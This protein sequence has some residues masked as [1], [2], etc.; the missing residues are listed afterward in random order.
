MRERD[1]GRPGRTG[2]RLGVLVALL[3]LL[4]AGCGQAG[5]TAPG[6]TAPAPGPTASVPSRPDPAVGA[7]PDLAPYYGQVL[8][9]GDCAPFAAAP[10]QRLAFADSALECAR[11]RVPLDYTNPRGGRDAS[12][13]LLRRRA[14]SP[15]ARIGSLVINPGG[16]GA[17]GIVTAAGLSSRVE[18][19]ELGR[20]FDLVGFDPR[21]VGA[22]TPTVRC[23]TGPE[24]D[25]QRA[26]DDTDPSPA[27]VAATEAEAATVA[28]DCAART[29]VDVLATVGT[30]DVARDLDVLR[31][32]L[33]DAGL[34]YLGYSYG[35]RIGSTYAQQF[36]AR[37]RAMV[38][39]G[40]LDPDADP[41]DEVVAQG[42]GFQGTFDAF[43]RDCARLPACPLGTDPAQATVRYQQLTRPLIDRPLPLPDG[44]VLSYADAQQGTIFDLYSSQNWPTL[45]LALADLTAGRGAVLMEEADQYFDR[46][47]DGRYSPEQDAFNAV[48]CV[49]DPRVS[50]P[51]RSMDRAARYDA[52]APFLA[53]GRGPTA[54]RDLCA[55]WPVPTTG[56]PGVPRVPGLAPP[57]VVS[58]TGDPA[59][60]YDAG[61]RLAAALGGSLL[62]K[63]GDQHTA[64]LQGFRCV[65]AAVTRY[66]VDLT[67]SAPGATCPAQ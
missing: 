59:T 4:L 58:T 66:L 27:G 43:A 6:P 62:T 14:S 20:R 37:V 29:G 25:A 44:R 56:A 42:R 21:G 60:P 61:V 57:L 28:G 13:A 26:D 33:G 9:W 40:A 54:A 31:A 8:A 65:D 32:A 35:T 30:R 7:P 12:L 5:P 67:P 55:F 49:D 2:P 15:D 38:L 52:A 23:L 18:G 10:D 51:G 24:Q 17:S 41:T 46:A 64:T 63:V 3:A 36:P 53:S 39:D 16:P 34:S 47:P 22:S 19:T 1:P 11:L 50:D 48:R 45:R